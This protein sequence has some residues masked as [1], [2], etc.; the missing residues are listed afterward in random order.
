MGKERVRGR[1]RQLGGKELGGQ[2][3]TVRGAE[4]VGGGLGRQRV[5]VLL[6]VES[7]GGEE[8]GWG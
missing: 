5:G 1:E 7:V 8:E 4:R 3:E 6:G 2:R